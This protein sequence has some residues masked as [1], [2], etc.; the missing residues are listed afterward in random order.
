MTNIVALLSSINNYIDQN[1]IGNLQLSGNKC[2]NTYK[3][4][5]IIINKYQMFKLLLIIVI[6]YLQLLSILEQM[7]YYLYIIYN[8]LRTDFFFGLLQVICAI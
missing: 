8:Y 2:I 4:K 1:D 6:I 7:N 5:L 3:R